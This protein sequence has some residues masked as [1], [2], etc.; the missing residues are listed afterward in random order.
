MTDD[1][2]MIY[3]VS[4]ICTMCKHYEPTNSKSIKGGQKCTA[5][6]AGIPDEIWLGKNDHTKPYEGDNGI[7]FERY[8]NNI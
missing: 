6:P 5:F 7:T 2:N 1:R 8:I 3:I 4:E